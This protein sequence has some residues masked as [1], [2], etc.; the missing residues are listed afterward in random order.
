MRVGGK[1]TKQATVES[2]LREYITRR[3]QKQI[4]DLFG[5]LEWD[6]GYDYKRGRGRR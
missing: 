2:A 5:T 4:L 1:K 6:E 3:E